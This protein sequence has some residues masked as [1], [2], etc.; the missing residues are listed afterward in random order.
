MGAMPSLTAAE[1]NRTAIC[2]HL[3][4]CSH[5]EVWL[6]LQRLLPERLLLLQQLLYLRRL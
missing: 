5:C 3:R 1:A 6:L 4:R 2:G